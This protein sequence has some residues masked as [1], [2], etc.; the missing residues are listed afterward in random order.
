M[1]QDVF[2]TLYGFL[3]GAQGPIFTEQIYPQVG[4]A[5]LVITVVAAA[6]YYY[7]L[8]WTT[9]TLNMLRHW[10]IALAINSAFCMLTVLGVSRLVLGGWDVDAPIVFTLSLIQALYAA[11]L[12]TVTSVVIKW[13]SPHARRTPF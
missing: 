5:L 9:A 2:S 12:F 3:H 7:W 1:I 11:L 8:G 13:G 6:L 4:A 10:F